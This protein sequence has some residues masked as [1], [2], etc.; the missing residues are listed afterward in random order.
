M[1]RYTSIQELKKLCEVKK[2]KFL[3]KE[4]AVFGTFFGI[5]R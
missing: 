1:R 2:G 3:L 5:V 4:T